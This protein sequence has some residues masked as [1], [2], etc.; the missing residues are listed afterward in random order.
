MV[1]TGSERP[2]PH[3]HPLNPFK[4]ESRSRVTGRKHGDPFVWQQE[5]P[6]ASGVQW[7][8]LCPLG[9]APNSSPLK[10]LPV[11]AP[12]QQ[13]KRIFLPR[14]SHY[15]MLSPWL[16]INKPPVAK[17]TGN[18]VVTLPTSTAELDGSRSS[19]DKGIVSYLWT[20]DETSPAAGVSGSGVGVLWKVRVRVG[21][22]GD[23]TLQ[24]L[25][26]QEAPR[27][28]SGIRE[29]DVFLWV[30]LQ[31]G[32]H[33]GFYL[34]TPG[35]VEGGAVAGPQQSCV[36]QAG[37]YSKRGVESMLFTPTGGAESLRPS[38]CPLPLQPG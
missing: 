6:G 26:S 23:P 25:V 8:W 10:V 4:A 16:E 2:G 28:C 31:T 32:V 17:I 9:Q 15:S 22:E 1:L 35:A 7:L 37:A 30:I 36:A 19:D 12:Q 14:M 13:H 24:C 21:E 38:P 18:V 27:L 11:L 3:F 33:S 5:S 20:R 29:S 34:L